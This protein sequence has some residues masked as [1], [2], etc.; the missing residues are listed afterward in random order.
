MYGLRPA[1]VTACPVSLAHPALSALL[2]LELLFYYYPLDGPVPRRRSLTSVGVR[3]A[4][5]VSM[6]DAHEQPLAPLR[7]LAPLPGFWEL[8][9]LRRDGGAR[10]TPRGSFWIVATATAD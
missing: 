6:A 9:A 5:G 7:L 1:H 2:T 10:M 4:Q 3:S 8:R